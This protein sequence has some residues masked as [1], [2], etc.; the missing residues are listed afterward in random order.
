MRNVFIWSGTTNTSHT[1]MS[2][3]CPTQ[4]LFPLD[5]PDQKMR[6]HIC[7]AGA[8]IAGTLEGNPTIRLTPANFDGTIGVNKIRAL[9]HVRT[10]ALAHAHR[11]FYDNEPTSTQRAEY[12]EMS[13]LLT[14]REFIG[15]HAFM[16]HISSLE[17]LAREMASFENSWGIGGCVERER[18]RNRIKTTK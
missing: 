16:Q 14:N 1:T 10:G 18:E 17:V 11:L 7:D 4:T 2:I 15:W 5:A 13:R 8:V 9:D 6:C 3:T 12:D